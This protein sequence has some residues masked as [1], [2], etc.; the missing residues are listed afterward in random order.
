MHSVNCD[1]DD[2]QIRISP[3]MLDKQ[4]YETGDMLHPQAA[5]YTLIMRELVKR[6][7]FS[8]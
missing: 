4:S 2:S 3:L 8:S 1:V 5:I 7:A 6:R